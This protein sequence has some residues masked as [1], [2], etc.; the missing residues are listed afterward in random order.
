MITYRTSLFDMRLDD[1]WEPDQRW[2][3]LSDTA[4]KHS[5]TDPLVLLYEYYFRPAGLLAI[6][7]DESARV[8]QQEVQD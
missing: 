2:A 6:H 1:L 7:V 4:S 3:L 5:R 8:Q